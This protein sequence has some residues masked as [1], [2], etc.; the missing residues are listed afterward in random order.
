M[1]A[2]AS[3]R[4]THEQMSAEDATQFLTDICVHNMDLMFLEPTEEVRM[5]P[6]PFGRAERMFRVVRGHISMEGF[7]HSLVEEIKLICAQRP[8]VT[9]RVRKLLDLASQLPNE[10]IDDWV[11]EHVDFYLHATFAV[12]ELSEAAGSPEPY[13]NM[14]RELDAEKLR[15]EVEQFSHSLWET[16]LS[17][18]MHAVLLLQLRNAQPDLL[19]VAL[20]LDDIGRAGLKRAQDFV[21]ALID[22]AVTPG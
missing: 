5:R 2:I 13:R 8:I 19:P 10:T 11:R 20:G 3:E 1:V 12:T 16:G 4:E 18:P 14:L 22:E 21:F 15:A 9:R 17:S 7:G 6:R